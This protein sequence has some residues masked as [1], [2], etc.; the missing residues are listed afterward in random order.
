MSDDPDFV[1]ESDSE[2]DD[3]DE[4]SH[5]DASD[6]S[7]PAPPAKRQ[8]QRASN[9]APRNRQ[10]AGVG[11]GCAN[12]TGCAMFAGVA[13][14]ASLAHL[15]APQRRMTVVLIML[16]T[17]VLVI[18]L[19]ELNASVSHVRHRVQRAPAEFG[20][21]FHGQFASFVKR[22]EDDRHFERYFRISP[23]D[24]RAIAAAITPELRELERKR[25]Q[26]GRRGAGFVEYD[27]RLAMMLRWLA[28]GSYLDIM[29]LYGVDCTSTFYNVLWDTLV[30]VDAA[31][32]ALSLESDLSDLGRCQTL[33]SGFAN[34]TSGWITGCIGALDG[35]L[36]QIEMPPAWWLNRVKFLSR[37]GFFALNVQAVC[38]ADRRFTYFSCECGG[39]AHDSLAWEA[40]T[41][42]DSKK[43]IQELLDESP[44]MRQGCASFALW[45][46]FLVADS[47]Y[48]C[49]RTVV[50]PW[51]MAPIFGSSDSFNFQQSRGR[52]NIE[53]SFGILLH[54]WLLFGRPLPW[55]M[56]VCEPHPTLGPHWKV[57]LLLRV[58]M[59]LH[60]QCIDTRLGVTSVLS[61]DFD[62]TY[63]V[64][65]PNQPRPAVDTAV[66]L[67]S[68]TRIPSHLSHANEPTSES[69]EAAWHPEDVPND[70]IGQTTAAG[71]ASHARTMMTRALYDQGV[72][73][74]DPRV[75]GEKLRN[76]A[77]RR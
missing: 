17:V 14:D 68:G 48:R 43:S 22:L 60:N 33:A 44:V 59:K 36:L 41:A 57:R 34:R 31:L 16:M 23:Q 25:T 35:L 26:G 7:Q 27:I 39:A 46:F 28:G 29:Y 61:H 62:G 15:S 3:E 13:A 1:P 32:P 50:T 76:D 64:V 52:I 71:R 70:L 11:L 30:R 73:R 18:L 24:F 51:A 20:L 53:C 75:F 47:A 21:R 56:L 72:I 49:C 5:S 77:T 55:R 58:A 8:R 19:A 45:G 42:V 66:H 12:N 6:A 37:K 2:V 9:V 54:K 69:P 40:A 65:R 63:E 74:T 67:S 4:T 10:T 38:D